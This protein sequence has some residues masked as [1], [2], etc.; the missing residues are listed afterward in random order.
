MSANIDMFRA[1]SIQD[2]R[3]PAGAGSGLCG[4]ARQPS[5]NTAVPI[6]IFIAN[7]QGHDATDSIAAAIDGPATAD[8]ATTTE[9]SASARPR[10]SL[11]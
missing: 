8:V 6:G 3:T 5:T 2:S 11:G 4:S 1:T 10:R 7:S 9:L